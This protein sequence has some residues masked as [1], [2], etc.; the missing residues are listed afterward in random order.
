MDATKDASVLS[1]FD[2]SENDITELYRETDGFLSSVNTNHPERDEN[3]TFDQF[4]Q[5]SHDALLE[6]RQDLLKKMALA[7]EG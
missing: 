7:S 4:L 5:T 6:K 3:E 2:L 1:E